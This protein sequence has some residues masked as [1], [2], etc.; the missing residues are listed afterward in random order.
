MYHLNGF[1]KYGTGWFDGNSLFRCYELYISS[2]GG[3]TKC[4]ESEVE[5]MQYTGLHDKKGNEIYEGDIVRF[6]SENWQVIYFEQY[7][8]FTLQNGN[9]LANITTQEEVVGNIYQNPELL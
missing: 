7:S 9:D 2:S 8:G 4:I 6:L 3:F 1:I 5:I